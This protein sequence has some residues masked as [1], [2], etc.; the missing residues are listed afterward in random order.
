MALRHRLIMILFGGLLLVPQGAAHAEVTYFQQ[1]NESAVVALLE[2]HTSENLVLGEW[3]LATLEVGPTCELRFGFAKGEAEVTATL[4]PAAGGAGSFA[5]AYAPSRPDD[6]GGPFE[7]LIAG[8]DPGG[9]FTERCLPP[10]DP[11][12][13]NADDAEETIEEQVAAWVPTPAAGLWVVALV[14]GLAGI[15]LLAWKGRKKKGKKDKKDVSPPPVAS[16][17]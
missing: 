16:G 12:K 6:L 1:G 2:P 7:A 5:Y 15:L 4:T 11:V 17:D 9:F 14:L 13:G 3:T 8:N 10:E